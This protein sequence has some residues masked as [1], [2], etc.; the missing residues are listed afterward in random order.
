VRFLLINQFYPPDVAPTGRFARDVV[1]GLRARGHD[2][3]VLA[4]RAAYATAASAGEMD[5]APTADEP[6]GSVRRLGPRGLGGRG[7]LI[8]AARALDFAGRVRLCLRGLRPRPDLVIV[9]TSPPFLGSALGCGDVPVAHWVMDLYP[10]ALA[11]HGIL[12]PESL[13][14]RWLVARQR[15]A[16]RRAALVLALGR[17]MEARLRAAGATAPLASVP[18]WGDGSD[19]EVGDTRATRAALGWPQESLVMLYSG[20]LGAAHRCSEFLETARRL[21]PDGPLWA[22]SGGGAKRADVVAF[23]ARYPEARVA[24]W[25]YA[26]AATHAQR[27]L[28]AD[29]HLA[30]LAPAWQGVVVPSKVVAAFSLGRPVLFVGPEENE[31]AEW[32]TSSGGGWVAA[33]D[34]VPAV[35]RAVREAT[36]LAE[37]ERRGAAARDFARRHFG[38][39]DNVG[40]VVALLEGAVGG[41]TAS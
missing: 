4:S 36:R 10:D 27:L 8:R 2:V 30:S 35:L 17:H 20:N 33:P 41:R 23:Q 1:G 16:W 6:A 12:R 21:G 3:L 29:V 19:V 37:R 40:R 25:P 14:Y 28:A 15:R 22:F 5:V 13:F 31:A 34:D 24:L 9:L 39:D 26:D 18:L 11:A 32:I 38:K 7:L